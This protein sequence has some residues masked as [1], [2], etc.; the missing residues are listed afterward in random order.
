MTD[1]GNAVYQKA[2]AYIRAAPDRAERTRRKAEV[3]HII[4]GTHTLRASASPPMQTVTVELLDISR[5]ED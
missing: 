1:A 2:V 5:R 4:Y 3:F